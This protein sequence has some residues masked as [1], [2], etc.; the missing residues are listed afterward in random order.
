M[1]VALLASAEPAWALGLA[2]AWARAG[3]A[4]TA[5]L[6]DAAAAAAREGHRDAAV[7]HEA[8]ASGVSVLA[9][10]DALRRRG[11]DVGTLAPG[12]KVTDLD[13]VADLI[14]DGADR[15]VWL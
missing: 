7:V 1:R 10:E 11:I 4:V 9:A 6:L 8:V 3:N 14:A 2:V 5:V 15:V 13:V 12:V